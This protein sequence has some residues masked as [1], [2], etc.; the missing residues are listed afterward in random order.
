MESGLA[1]VGAETQ[2]FFWELAEAGV[3]GVDLRSPLLPQATGEGC[4]GGEGNWSPGLAKG[5]GDLTFG[6]SETTGRS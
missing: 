2:W 1:P 4:R 5:G 6:V 3:E